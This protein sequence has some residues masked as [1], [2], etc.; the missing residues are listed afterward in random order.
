MGVLSVCPLFYSLCAIVLS[1]TVV[2]ATPL[3]VFAQTQARINVQH[4]T[5][6]GPD[7]FFLCILY[8]CFAN[9]LLI[10]LSLYLSRTH[11]QTLHSLPFYFSLS[12]PLYSWLSVWSL[13]NKAPA[14]ACS[15]KENLHIFFFAPNSF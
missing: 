13:Y 9:A 14:S 10:S 2:L 3:T 15:A 8:L 4:N 11:K 12:P 6:C 1:S 5:V 7:N